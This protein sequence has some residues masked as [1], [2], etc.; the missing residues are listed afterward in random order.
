MLYRLRDVIEELLEAFFGGQP[1]ERTEE[2]AREIIEYGRMNTKV[3]GIILIE[4]PEAARRLRESPRHIRKSLRLLRVKGMAHR[5]R[6]QNH[7]RLSA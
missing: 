6:D 4:V 3:P 1:P 2:L 5:T 7:W